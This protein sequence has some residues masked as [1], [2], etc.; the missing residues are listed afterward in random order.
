M[1]SLKRKR[2]NLKNKLKTFQEH[3]HV[4]QTRISANQSLN[5][6]ELVELKTRLATVE[7]SFELLDDIQNQIEEEVQLAQLPDAH[8]ERKAIEDLYYSST[9]IAKAILNKS[10]SSDGQSVADS[11]VSN[12]QLNIKLPVIHLPK[13]NGD[14]DTWL[15]YRDTFVSL[16]H[17][18]DALTEIQK[19]HYL[20]SSLVGKASECIKNMTFSAANY[21]TA[22]ESICDRYNDTRNLIFTHIRSMF[23][24]ETVPKESSGKLRNLV[25]CIT[26]NI[27]SLK[28]LISEKE[29]GEAFLVYLITSKL[30]AVT[31]R[32]W[33]QKITST[34]P[35]YL[36]LE[37]FLKDKASLLEKLESKRPKSPERRHPRQ[38][39][40]KS[41]LT[42]NKLSCPL[43]QK[44][45]YL[46]KCD[47]FVNLSV[48][49]RVSKIQTLNL[50]PNCF[51]KGHNLEGCKS[52]F[53]CRKCKSRH[54]T[55]LHEDV[56]SQ[57]QTSPV[58]SSSIVTALASTSSF[59]LLSTVMLEIEDSV[60]KNHLAR[61]LLDSGSQSDFI[62]E[63]FC[64]RLSVNRQ[65]ANITVTGIT[66]ASSPIREK[67]NLKLHS[68]QTSY[69]LQTSFLIVPEI[70]GTLPNYHV[71]LK[72]FNLPHHVQL[73]DPTFN[74]PG[75]V[76]I[77]L[78]AKRFWEFILEGKL[79]CNPSLKLQNTVFGW[80][81][82]GSVCKPSHHQ[83]LSCNVSQEN[84]NLNFDLKQFWELE[85]VPS[86]KAL[87]LE[88]RQCEEHY[89][90]T[91][92]RDNQ[93]RF[94]VSIPLKLPENL[95]GDSLLS[96][97]KQFLNL[98]RRLIKNPQLYD[99]YRAFMNEYLRLGHMSS[100]DPKTFNIAYF[101]PHHGVT[102]DNSLTTKLR[103]VFN[104]SAPSKNG[105]SI[106]SLQSVGPT[107]QQ[108]LVSILLRFRQHNIVM[109]ADI[110]K[111]YRQVLITPSQRHLQCILWRP[112]PYETLQA[113]HLNT[114]TYGTAAAPFLA[115]R[116]LVQLAMDTSDPEISE[117]IK[118]D[119][120]VDDLLTGTSTAT[121]AKYIISSLNKTLQSGCFKLRKWLSNRPE[122]LEG[123][124]I[125]ELHPHLVDFQ[126]HGI[127]KT[128]GMMWS[129]AKDS[130]VYSIANTPHP[131][132]TKRTILSDIAK[133]FDPLGLVSPSVMI[134]KRIIQQLW[135]HKLGWDQ[136]IP[137]ELATN[138]LKYKGQLFE[139]SELTIPRQVVCKDPST[140]DLHGFCDASNIGYGACIY[141]VSQGN[142]HNT[143]S[144]LLCAKARVAPL[145][146]VTIP[147]LELCGAQLLSKLLSHCLRALTIKPTNI[148]LWSDS[149]VV[150]G[151]LKIPPNLLKPFVSNRVAQIQDLT[152][153]ATWRH[154]PTKENPADALSRGVMPHDL[155]LLDIWWHG[156]GFLI[157]DQSTWPSSTFKCHVLP[158]VKAQETFTLNCHSR[159][160]DLDIF[161]KFSCISTLERVVAYCYRFLHNC[162][163]SQQNRITGSLSPC[164]I[165]HALTRLILNAQSQCFQS[166][167]K[168][169]LNQQPI[170]NAHINKL[171]PFID[172]NG[173]IR[174]GGRLNN[175]SF[176]FNKLHPILLP[177]KHAI[178]KLLFEREHK[179]LLHTGSQHLLAS[180]R[181]KFWP[182]SGRNVARQVVH[183]CITCFRAN[184]KVV[185]PPLMGNLPASRLQ[186]APPFFTTG[187]D[188]AGPF[189]IKD[190]RG[191]GC[192]LSKAYICLFI[193]FCTKAVHL[194]LV[195][196]LTTEC[197]ILALRRFVSR[198]GVPKSIY[199]DNG[200]T[201]VGAR[202]EL[203]ELGE[204]LRQNSSDII[205][206]SQNY[207]IDWHFIPAYS[208][209]FGG[210]WEAGVKSAK[211]HL[212]R[213]VANASLT[214][215]GMSTLLV[216]I[217]AVLNSRPLSPMSADPSD[218]T[219]LTPA[220]FLIGRPLT[221]I[222]ANHLVD[223]PVSRLSYHQQIQRMQQHFWT[224][225]SKE[226][227]SELQQ[228]VKWKTSQTNIQPGSIVVIKEDNL[229][230]LQWK[231][232][233][234]IATH[235][236]KDAV[237]RVVSVKT[238]NGVVKRAV[239]KV[240]PL[241]LSDS[242]TY[243]QDN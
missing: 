191:R 33:E 120:Y 129:H 176:P 151:W 34:T 243:H 17:D 51:R 29:L 232:G 107:I 36:E 190:K 149:T 50:C 139:L 39:S 69:S 78:G 68:L 10:K 9:G 188:Y 56:V 206:K 239:S 71:N 185:A 65:N 231:L 76:D 26:K 125:D 159:P 203:N 83:H 242:K 235:S 44:D 62:S 23:L 126:D 14:A 77:L 101:L 43:C 24:I 21:N 111:M 138:W 133:I 47:L 81:V 18:N 175:A 105:Y 178:T 214:Y 79:S 128:L 63:E 238:S 87:S 85:E 218:T 202:S 204:F 195:T 163:S 7:A 153:L 49:D 161:L 162:R 12:T 227:I 27:R 141:I 102:N 180:I 100:C 60:G 233:R 116:S 207:R 223:V 181:D 48:R 222:P 134:P 89:A 73:A 106:N 189:L 95:L 220:H 166:E 211:Y 108:D 154:I 57:H 66:S 52:N 94:I 11:S 164:E 122:V 109:C 2:A 213:V 82:T 46:H 80:I 137:S 226:Y 90:Q 110:E 205:Q 123:L 3:I 200:R 140:I 88:E 19:F 241:P 177:A 84:V 135:L 59:V 54:N 187:V 99:K 155:K 15:E 112:S 55:M 167:L 210:L 168:L 216:Q 40:S 5:E 152:E 221:T 192:K 172:S 237:T 124:Q 8:A 6:H 236:G 147:R 75:K 193:C 183:Q 173:L 20:R 224:R 215:E 198:R 142:D 58:Q 119:F 86:S 209:H 143:S 230:P 184:P 157:N 131:T 72:S 97:E 174:V 186:P 31:V 104:G 148:Y 53:V 145:K 225:W 32:E 92:S 234:I 61:A 212:K 199:S 217:E 30:D 171:N 127:S 103:V 25:D 115:I 45:H 114:V 16:I 41:F 121:H 136:T 96:A 182:L 1:E 150:L 240:C 91:Y 132:I 35:T 179:R 42:T 93:G 118:R 229:H 170:Q 117:I 113:Y 70:T 194:E 146:P 130:F 144:H 67:C 13:F 98:E 28:S 228:R 4:I 38:H 196:D 219:P 169:L 160:D 165:E 158:D 201:F 74:Q 22:W 156:P 208:P 197:F 37:Q 64:N